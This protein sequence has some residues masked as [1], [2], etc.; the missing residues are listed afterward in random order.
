M[1]C[2]LENPILFWH[3]SPRPWV[4]PARGTEPEALQFSLSAFNV[5]SSWK[6]PGLALSQS[7]ALL[8]GDCFATWPNQRRQACTPLETLWCDV[9]MMDSRYSLNRRNP[10]TLSATPIVSNG[11]DFSQA[12]RWQLQR[13]R[14]YLENINVGAC[15]K[16]SCAEVHLSERWN[17]RAEV[18]QAQSQWQTPYLTLTTL[19]FL[20]YISLWHGWM[21]W[22][23]VTL[24]G[25]VIDVMC[26]SFH[27]QLRYLKRVRKLKTGMCRHCKPTDFVRQDMPQNFIK[28]LLMSS[29]YL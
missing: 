20:T 23:F 3:I 15:P 29:H 17:K 16:Q 8:A 13:V 26:C 19:S 14:T 10:A 6:G 1:A 28:S 27:A 4:C 21:L 18:A 22:Y 2:H 24:W 12:P 5:E 11:G 25:G 9:M 7:S